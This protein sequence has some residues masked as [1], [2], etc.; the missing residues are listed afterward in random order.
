MTATIDSLI[1]S[2]FGVGVT[3]VKFNRKVEYYQWVENSKSQTKDKIAEARRPSR[4]TR[5]RRNG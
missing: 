1:D 5:M 2:D 4:P 3:A